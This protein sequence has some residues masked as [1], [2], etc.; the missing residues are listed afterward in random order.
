[1]ERSS[2]PYVTRHSHPVM[3]RSAKPNRSIHGSALWLSGFC[4]CGR[5]TPFA[6]NDG[7]RVG[8]TSNRVPRYTPQGEIGDAVDVSSEAGVY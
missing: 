3:L 4:D 8:V 2:S 7:K 1:V 6:Q 5:S